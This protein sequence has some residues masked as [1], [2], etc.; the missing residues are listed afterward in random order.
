MEDILDT[1]MDE[2]SVHHSNESNF[3]MDQLIQIMGEYKY[4]I[5]LCGSGTSQEYGMKTFEEMKKENYYDIFSLSTFDYDTLF[6]YENFN[7][8]KKQCEML[9]KVIIPSTVFMITTNIDHVFLGENVYEIHGSVNEYQCNVCKIKCILDKEECIPLCRICNTILRPWIQLYG[10]GDFL[11]DVQ[12]EKQYRHFK[13]FPINE[14]LVFEIGCGT[15]VPLLRNESIS[16]HKR[17][18]K[19]VQVNVK[20]F[21]TTFLSITCKGGTFINQIVD[22]IHT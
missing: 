22:Y 2:I 9:P 7:I 10:D 20:D 6:F 14:T 18:Y 3:T 1:L 13:Q 11:S 17:G 21:H 19:V 16:L 12:K 8:I 5:F 15:K 4:F